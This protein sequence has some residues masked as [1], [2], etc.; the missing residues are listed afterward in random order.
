[1]AAQWYNNK[2]GKINIAIRITYSSVV[3]M[4]TLVDLSTCESR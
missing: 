4:L 2:G 3:T 1:M